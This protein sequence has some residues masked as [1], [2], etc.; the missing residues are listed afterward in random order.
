MATVNLGP[1]LL[2]IGA[3]GA[4]QHDISCLINNARITTEKDQADPRTH[5]CGT[6]SPGAITYTFA[7]SGNLD[8]DIADA[9]GFFAFSQDHAGEQHPFTFTPNTAATTSAA[10]NLVVDPLEFGADEYGD[11]LDSDFE[12]SVIGKPTYTYPTT[13]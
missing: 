12:F 6:S 13:P 11:P 4:D 10:G 5:L 3:I 1:G 7:L 2:T 9:D 8:V